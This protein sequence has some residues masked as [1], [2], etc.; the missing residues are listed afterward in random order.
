[1]NGTGAVVTLCLCESP[2]IVPAFACSTCARE[3]QRSASLRLPPCCPAPFVTR[4]I[5]S[6]C[7][8]LPAEAHSRR[9][10][11]RRA[12]SSVGRAPALHAGCQGFESLTAHHDSCGGQT[13]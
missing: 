5:S 4:I 12:V 6:G 2:T 10:E 13:D 11:R 9:G 7:R 3:R 8:C 1:M